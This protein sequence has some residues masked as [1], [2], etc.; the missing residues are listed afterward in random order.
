MT[1]PNAPT[2]RPDPSS[3]SE[4]AASCIE[5]AARFLADQPGAVDRALRMHRRGP[6]GRCRGCGAAAPRWP[7]AVATSALR[8]RHLVEG[9]A[10]FRTVLNV[11]GEAE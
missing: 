7:C 5:V 4:P 1:V 9:P 3:M 11:T 10:G 2:G 6:N 8:A